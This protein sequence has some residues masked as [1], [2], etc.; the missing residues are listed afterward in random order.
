MNPGHRDMALA[1]FPH[2]KMG[3][4]WLGSESSGKRTGRSQRTQIT[5]TPENAEFIQR[6]G[7]ANE[8]GN[9]RYNISAEVNLFLD[10]LRLNHGRDAIILDI[11]KKIEAS[12]QHK[13]KL[14]QSFLK[15]S[16]GK[17]L[18]DWLADFYTRENTKQDA[19]KE[20]EKQAN[21]RINEIYL[22]FFDL[23]HNASW[24]INELVKK[25]DPYHRGTLVN[26]NRI[27]AAGYKNSQRDF[28]RDYLIWEAQHENNIKV[29]IKD[30][31]KQ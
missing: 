8:T 16:G 29:E 9:G 4:C 18:N 15:L 21:E 1:R 5:V 10:E 30:K 12:D 3:G 22:E 7:G 28:I 26:W 19:I 20:Y 17:D 11:A 6:F 23:I 25:P 27:L 14:M 2:E 24:T 31:V 13:D